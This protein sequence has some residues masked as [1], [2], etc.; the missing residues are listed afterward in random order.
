MKPPK[1]ADTDLKKTFTSYQKF[2]VA[3]L[4]F[5]QFTIILDF[6]ILSPLGFLYASAQHHSG[7]VRPRRFDLCV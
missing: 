1:D 2:V 6:M 4:A 7:A 3:L 5:L